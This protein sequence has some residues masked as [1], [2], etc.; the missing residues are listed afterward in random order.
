[1]A[2]YTGRKIHGKK[3]KL[4][5]KD[6]KTFAKIKPKHIWYHRDSLDITFKIKEFNR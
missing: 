4:L 1:M 5:K 6:S 3:M 2:G